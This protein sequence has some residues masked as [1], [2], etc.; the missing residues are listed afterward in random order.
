MLFCEHA[1][2]EASGQFTLIGLIAGNQMHVS[3]SGPSAPIGPITFANFTVMAVLDYMTGVTELETQCEVLKGTEVVQRT[4]PDKDRRANP[5]ARYHTHAVTF[6]PLMLP[7]P[8]DYQFKIV[9]KAEG[10]T[11][12]FAR[13]LLIRGD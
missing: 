2:Q 6:T 3:A 8:G 12:S 10:R 4:P 7:G 11:L 5:K 1:R 13:K 9:V